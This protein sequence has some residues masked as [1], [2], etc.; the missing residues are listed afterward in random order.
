MSLADAD[1]ARVHTRRLLSDP[2]L[3]RRLA[4]HAVAA[5]KTVRRQVDPSP[6]PARSPPGRW[7]GDGAGALDRGNWCDPWLRR[8]R[9]APALCA[10]G[11][12][13]GRHWRRH[14]GS[15]APAPP[16]EA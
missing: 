9:L 12:A 3:R 15:V 16:D 14:P 7:H 13:L 10:V 4:V 1:A 8:G 6:S 5:A 2:R 11:P